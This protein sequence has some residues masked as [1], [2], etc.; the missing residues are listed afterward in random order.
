[1]GRLLDRLLEGSP[2]YSVKRDAGG[3]LLTGEPSRLGEFADVV[4]EAASHAGQD[5]IVFP[6][7]DGDHGYDQMFVIPIN[8]VPQ[9]TGMDG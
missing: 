5:F 2:A 3:F 6:I 8:E 9:A 4:R 1:M 7:S